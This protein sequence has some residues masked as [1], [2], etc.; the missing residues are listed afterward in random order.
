[1]YGPNLTTDTHRV[2]IKINIASRSSA[3]SHAPLSTAL[4]AMGYPSEKTS[5]RNEYS[6]DSPSI[7]DKTQNAAVQR[8]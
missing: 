1:L 8:D 7:I 3:L 5:P 4:A 2:L 6:Q